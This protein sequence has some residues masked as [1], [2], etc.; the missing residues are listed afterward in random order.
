MSDIRRIFMTDDRIFSGDV[1][2]DGHDHLDVVWMDRGVNHQIS[3]PKDQIRRTET[4]PDHLAD[5]LNRASIAL[6]L[7]P[8]CG[9]PTVVRGPLPEGVSLRGTAGDAA[10]E[11]G[12]HAFFD[13]QCHQW[14]PVATPGES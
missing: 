9:P 8:A 12:E 4:V 10:D 13:T 5:R 11:A 7:D 14:F 6:R 2:L 3:V 1:V